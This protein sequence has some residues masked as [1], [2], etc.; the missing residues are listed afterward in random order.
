[1]VW[2]KNCNHKEQLKINTDIYEKDN[3]IYCAL[4]GEKISECA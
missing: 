1:M 3:I 2:N 4:C